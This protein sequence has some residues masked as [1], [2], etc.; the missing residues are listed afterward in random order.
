LAVK[1]R[2]EQIVQVTLDLLI[3]KGFANVSTRDLAERAGLSRSHIY[4]Y[5]QDWPTLRQEA[6]TRFADAQLAETRAAVAGLAPPAA[7]EAFI[8]DCLSAE[9]GTGMEL[10]LDAW[11]EALHDPELAAAYAA[12]DL[13]WHRLLETI[14]VDGVARGDFRCAS[15]ERAARQIFAMTMGYADDVLMSSDAMSA[16]QAATEVIEAATLILGS[17]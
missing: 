16:E 14:I 2:R 10:W 4:H 11:D 8:R 6:F 1:D 3:E 5:F 9:P 17:A 15:P 12:T 13:R 7:V